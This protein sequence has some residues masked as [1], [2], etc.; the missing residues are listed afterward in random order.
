MFGGTVGYSFGEVDELVGEGVELGAVFVSVNEGLNGNV[1][2]RDGKVVDVD[3][4]KNI[5]DGI[6]AFEENGK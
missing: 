1:G 6:K 3:G 5:G 4:G 2:G